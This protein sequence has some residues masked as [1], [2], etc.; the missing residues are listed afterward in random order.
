MS[1]PVVAIVGRPNVGKSTLF[2]RIIRQREA[3]VDNHPG[4]TRDRKYAEA[5]W[6]GREFILIDTG[7]WLPGSHDRIEAAVYQQVNIAIQEADLTVFL[8]DAVT[9][10]TGVDEEIAGILQRSGAPVVL[11]VNKADTDAR[12][13]ATADFYR[14]GLGEPVPLSAASGRGVGDFLD[15][16]VAKLP[17]RGRRRGPDGSAAMALAVVG[18]PNVGKSSFINALLGEERHIVTEIPGTT[19]DAVDS[20]FKYYGEEIR[21][22]DTAGLRRKSRVQD[23][24]EFYSTVRSFQSIRRADVVVLMIDAT[25]ELE[26]QDMRILQEAV[27]LN[28]GVVLVVNKWDLIE[29]DGR[30]ADAYERR[31]RGTLKRLD[32]VPILFISAKTGKRLYKVIDVA[33]SVYRERQKRIKTSELN[34]FLREA[35][36]HYAPPSMNRK[37]VTIKYCAQVKS[38]PPVIA[39]FTNAAEAITANYK[40]YLENQL[41]ERF[42]FLGVPLT[43]V[44]RNK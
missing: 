40:L 29:K 14:L 35:V 18:R 32:Y 28:K 44:F 16:V 37:E 10:L 9:G 41:R 31:L 19:R 6:A 13:L 15:E 25:L 3:I 1:L 33:K 27:R 39:F 2:N 34:A 42:G 24:V 26:R 23:A 4:V 38:N 17:E 8:V 11:G 30:T 7:G 5:E 43:L 12:E 21:L 36:T 22:I 20:V